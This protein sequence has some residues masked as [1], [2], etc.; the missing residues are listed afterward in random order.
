M[1]R[2]RAAKSSDLQRLMEIS[3]HSVTAAHW[4]QDEYAKLF[5]ADAAQ[6]TVL[7]VEENGLVQGFIVAQPI[8][9]EWEIENIAIS[10]P[11]RRRGLGSRLL[12]E[13][14]HHS[15]SKGGQ[16]VFLE[17]RESNRAAQALYE[18]W[19]F[20]KSGRRKT[21]YHAPDEDALIYKFSFPQESKPSVKKR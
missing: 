1:V 6:R 10:G 17:V 21:Y 4:N 16:D 5:A 19:A 14:L 15:R 11:A 2:V 20:V 7:V 8:E 3:R 12:G 13:F 18:K 9:A